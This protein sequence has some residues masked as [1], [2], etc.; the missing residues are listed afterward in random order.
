MP[1]WTVTHWHRWRNHDPCQSDVTTG[2]MSH[3]SNVTCLTVRFQ[4]AVHS[5]S[6][7]ESFVC[8]WVTYQGCSGVGTAFLHLFCTS[9]VTWRCGI[10][11][12]TLEHGCDLTDGL[13]TRRFALLVKNVCRRMLTLRELLGAIFLF[14]WFGNGAPTLLFLKLQPWSWQQQ[15]QTSSVDFQPPTEPARSE[16]PI[17]ERV[18]AFQDPYTSK[19]WFSNGVMRSHINAPRGALISLSVF[20]IKFWHTCTFLI[21]T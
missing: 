5:K 7:E 8:Q 17:A 21:M 10:Q 4:I 6:Y 18:L 15:S 3:S 13:A 19:Q 16:I 20:T 12:I 11:T 9:N 1:P 14:V 2:L